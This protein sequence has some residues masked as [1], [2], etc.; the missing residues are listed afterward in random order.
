MFLTGLLVLLLSVGAFAAI[1]RV[2]PKGELGASGRL[3]G[4][5]AA[6][7]VAL[8]AVV[9]IWVMLSENHRAADRREERALLERSPIAA[10]QVE[11]LD[12]T[13]VPGAHGPSLH[14]WIRNESA[15]TLY[16]IDFRWSIPWCRTPDDCHPVG[17]R[18]DQRIDSGVRPGQMV[19]WRVDLL[20]NEPSQEMIALGMGQ[21]PT[22][23]TPARIEVLAARGL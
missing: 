23:Q 20:S 3:L 17:W 22:E 1:G 6:G 16:A 18:C 21:W 13:F 11:I 12:P 4:L 9:S 2:R 14:G 15:R 8:W 19:P 7:L 10:S 5:V